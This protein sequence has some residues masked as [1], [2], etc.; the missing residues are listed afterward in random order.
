MNTGGGFQKF[1]KIE[2]IGE[3][4]YGTVYKAKN[5]ETQ[6]VVAL[7][8]VRLDED[9]EGVPSSALREICI[10]KELRHRNIVR[11][12]EFPILIHFQET[13]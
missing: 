5:R 11:S 1:E 4:T 12:V 9:D 10:L 3:G 13:H 2:K 8:R 7:K 6:E